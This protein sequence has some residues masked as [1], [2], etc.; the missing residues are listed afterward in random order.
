M[1]SRPTKGETVV[2]DLTKNSFEAYKL[3]EENETLKRQLDKLDEVNNVNITQLKNENETLRKQ[4]EELLQQIAGLRTQEN[5][6]IEVNDGYLR[7]DQW[8]TEQ[9]TS[10]DSGRSSMRLLS[11]STEGLYDIQPETENNRTDVGAPIT[12]VNTVTEN[13]SISLDVKTTQPTVEIPNRSVSL[14]GET[15]KSKEQRKKEKRRN[16]KS[17][18]LAFRQMSDIDAYGQGLPLPD[19]KKHSRAQKE[20]KRLRR[21]YSIDKND[22]NKNDDSSNSDSSSESKNQQR[23]LKIQSF[24]EENSS[25]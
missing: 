10:S 12:S 15:I 3:R 8:V 24:E 1:G 6:H 23:T 11:S 20:R 19:A 4:N 13:R 17:K 14:E 25:Y 22:A 9:S 5:K 16:L 2:E 18:S 21:E 7:V